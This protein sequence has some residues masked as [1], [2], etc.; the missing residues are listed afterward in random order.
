MRELP[1]QQTNRPKLRGNNGTPPATITPPPNADDVSAFTASL[2]D[3][4]GVGALIDALSG[5]VRAPALPLATAGV[6]L[7]NSGA[8][9]GLGG[10]SKFRSWPL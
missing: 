8:A 6:R 7:H 4:L 5:A 3:H 9:A 2:P 1:P 10:H